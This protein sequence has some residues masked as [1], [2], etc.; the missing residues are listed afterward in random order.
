MAGRHWLF[1]GSD[2]KGERTAGILSVIDTAKLNGIDA[3]TSV[4]AAKRPPPSASLSIRAA[5]SLPR[6][7]RQIL[8]GQIEFLPRDHGDCYRVNYLEA[9]GRESIWRPFGDITQSAKVMTDLDF[10]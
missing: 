7:R 6:E 8:Y 3:L 1:A 4:P 10:G 2:N 5:L 9:W